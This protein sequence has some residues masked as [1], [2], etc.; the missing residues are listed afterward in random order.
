MHVIIAFLLWHQYARHYLFD[1]LSAALELEYLNKD[2][3][4][5][6]SIIIRPF[7]ISYFLR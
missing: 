7:K 4:L 6:I 5:Y 2:P 3:I 1:Q